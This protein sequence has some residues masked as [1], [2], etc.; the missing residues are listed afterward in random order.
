MYSFVAVL[1]HYIVL[2]YSLGD[3]IAACNSRR[4]DHQRDLESSPPGGSSSG[5]GSISKP[6]PPSVS[7]YDKE[8][9]PYSGSSSSKNSKPSKPS[10]REDHDASVQNLIEK[11]QSG[12][13]IKDVRASEI[14]DVY[15]HKLQSLQVSLFAL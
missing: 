14:I 3:S 2:Y 8:N 6:R 13:D 11:M 10:K 1:L 4:D 12:M 7:M 15:E 9:I 5:G